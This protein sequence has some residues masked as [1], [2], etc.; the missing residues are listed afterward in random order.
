MF[1]FSNIKSSRPELFCK[2]VFIN[3][4]LNVQEIAC[5]N[6]HNGIKTDVV[7]VQLSFLIESQA[8]E[9]HQEGG[10]GNHM[11]KPHAHARKEIVTF[12][13][14]EEFSLFYKGSQSNQSNQTQ[15]EITK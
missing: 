15:I 3:I 5:T 1:L 14:A 13:F 8:V 7:V 10:S 11:Q 2:K 12:L 4:W 9:N 6:R